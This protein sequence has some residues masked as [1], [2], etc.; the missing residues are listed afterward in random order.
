[1]S[2]H[3]QFDSSSMSEHAKLA[4]WLQHVLTSPIPETSSTATGDTSPTVSLEDSTDHLHFYQQIPDFA[5]A[6]L[7]KEPQAT[8]RYAPLLYHLA[9]CLSCHTAYL[10]IYDALGY[11]LTAGES[12]PLVNQGSRP[13]ATIP[14]NTLVNLCQ[15]LISQAE[16]VLR[17]ARHEH[18]DNDALARSLLQ[19]A[20]RVSTHIHQSSMRPKALKELVRVATLFDG[21]HSPGEYPA[22]THA[23]TP[24]VGAGGPRRGKVVRRGAD[25][26]ARSSRK[27]SGEP[28]IYLQAHPLEGRI[29]Q[30]G[31]ALHLHLE[32]LEASLRGQYLI[33]SVPLGSLLE[34]VRWLGGNPRAI[35]SEAQ[36]AADGTLTTTLGHTDLQLSNTDDRNL[37]EVLF[38]LVEVRSV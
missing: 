17:Q 14:T 3:K 15:M 37:L 28:A 23:Y 21:P 25:T 29:T 19:L 22:A 2:D 13:L 30:H 24:L 33:I 8:L 31:D 26:A 5:M 20:M 38:S 7:R 27:A 32:D 34:P 6:L 9:S 4:R 11:A 1:M 36:V 10:E 16:A 35:R 12:V 18:T